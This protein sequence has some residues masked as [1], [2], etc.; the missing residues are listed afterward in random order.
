M[1]AAAKLEDLP[2]NELM[3]KLNRPSSVTSPNP[4]GP[5]IVGIGLYVH[6]ITEIDSSRNSFALEGFLDLIWCDSRQKFNAISSPTKMFLEK[7]AE[8]EL[9]LIW[10]PDSYFANQLE[11]RRI[12]NEELIIF[13]DGTIE[14]REKFGVTLA[15]NYDMRRF[16]FDTQ[17]LRAEIESFAWSSDILQFQVEDELIDF[18]TDF[19]IPEWSM[20]DLNEFLGEKMEGR[21]RSPFSESIVEITVNRDPNCYLVKVMLPLGL[22]VFIYWGV[23][24]MRV[25]NLAD[26]MAV[27]FA[28][29]LIAVAYMVILADILPKHVYNTFLDNY[30]LLCL[31]MMVLTVIENIVVVLIHRHELESEI[32]MTTEG[33]DELESEIAN[34]RVDVDEGDP[35]T[36]QLVDN[37][38]IHRNDR[39]ESVKAKRVDAFARIGFPLAF[40]LVTALLA[41]GYLI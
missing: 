10:W 18:S 11:P 39:V 23:F 6:E 21:D 1:E 31:L 9:E 3:I 35:E 27:S 16:P 34:L 22:I 24:W 5:T 17:I 38:I 13:A 40:V 26:R 15:S 19:S 41:M 36:S 30:V 37:L 4:D 8:Q 25:D 33:V 20:I 14:Y 7:D 28:G 32:S 2:L 29:V 12:E